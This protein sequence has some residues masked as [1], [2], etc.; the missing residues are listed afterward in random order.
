MAIDNEEF[1]EGLKCIGAPVRDH[2]G[3]VI[4][5]I[6]VAGP[7]FR[8]LEHCMP[9]LT[10]SVVK[11]AEEL[12]AALGYRKSRLEARGLTDSDNPVAG[13]IDRFFDCEE[14]L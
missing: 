8:L 4:A 6:S 9:T 11:A 12:A 10:S 3:D 1:E 5:A 2:S 7:A 14:E 13:T